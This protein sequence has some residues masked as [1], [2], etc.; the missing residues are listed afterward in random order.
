MRLTWPDPTL[1]E[2][3]YN[4][5]VGPGAPF[6]IVTEDVLGTPMQ[7]FK[8]RP[9]SL[10]EMLVTAA[11]RFGDRPY[12][13]FPERTVTYEDVLKL[14]KDKVK[15]N[16]ILQKVEDSPTAFTLSKAQIDELRAAGC[17]RIY[18]EHGSGAS[19]A[20]SFGQIA[21]R[22]HRGRY[23]RRRSPRSAGQP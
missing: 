8:N 3:V 14:L 13:V 22:A 17:G 18:Q 10:R 20:P 16:R 9:K 15:E 12:V 5:L 19:R 23:P 2:A 11:E 6:E 1:P 7:V 21:W 4:G